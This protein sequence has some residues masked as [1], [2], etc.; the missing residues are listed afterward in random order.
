MSNAMQKPQRETEIRW[1]HERLMRYHKLHRAG[2]SRKVAAR[3]VLR[4]MSKEAW[5]DAAERLERT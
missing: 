1:T 2:F 3:M 5:A 4:D